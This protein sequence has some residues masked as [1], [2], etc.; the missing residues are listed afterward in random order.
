MSSGEGGGALKDF[1]RQCPLDY[2][3]LLG[4]VS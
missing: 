4:I 2:I 1:E 3:T